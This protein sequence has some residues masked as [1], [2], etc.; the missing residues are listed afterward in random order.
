[1]MAGKRLQQN[2]RQFV[3]ARLRRALKVAR[4]EQDLT[5]EDVV[6]R[7]PSWAEN[8]VDPA[9]LS[10][11]EKGRF[12]PDAVVL[13]AIAHAYGV[14]EVVLLAKLRE[15]LEEWALLAVA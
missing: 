14:S 6:G 3:A 2:G 10:R 8:I 7:S 1:M 4:A 13:I 9:T 5:L 12:R 11:Y 15:D